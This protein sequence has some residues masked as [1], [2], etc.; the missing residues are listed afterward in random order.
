[1]KRSCYFSHVII[2]ATTAKGASTRSAIVAK[3][4]DIARVE[5]MESL[6]I[7]NVAQAVGMSKSGVFAHFGS[8]EDLQLAV[9]D[10]VAEDFIQ[11]VMEPAFAQPRGLSRLRALFAG[12][13]QWVVKSGCP[14]I[15]AAIE[16]DDR[17]GR[18][19]D[20]VVSMERRLR[21]SL[22]RTLGIAIETGELAAGVDPEQM[23]FEL[24][25]IVLALHH[26]ARLLGSPMAAARANRAFDHL[27]TA[28]AA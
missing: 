17:R 21:E 1:M 10:G 9:L 3:A 22:A 24:F 5:G 26:D 25:G 27:L 7:G 28:N 13:L 18:I 2:A 11:T 16:Y 6:S 14:L 19:H 15:S 8:R 23:A 4:A 20:R 12:W